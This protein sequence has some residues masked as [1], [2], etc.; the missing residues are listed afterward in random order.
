MVSVVITTCNRAEIL[1][2]ALV[3]VLSQTYTA[4]EIIV[5]DDG[6]TDETAAVVAQYGQR[7][8]YVRQ[9]NQGVE[10]ARKRGIQA[11]LGD[12]ITFLDDDDLMAPRKIERQAAILD[13]R[14][15]VGVVHCGY[16]YIDKDGNILGMSGRLPE[17]DMRRS[18]VWGCSPWSGGPLIRRQC[19]DCFGAEE[20]PDWYSD[21]GMWLRITLVGNQWACVQEPLGDYRIVQGSMIDN[22]IPNAERLV[23]HLL[24]EVFGNWKLP[25]E[26]LAEKDDIYAGWHFWISCRYYTVGSWEDAQRNLVKC[27]QL[28]PLLLDHPEKLI[29]LLHRDATSPRVR[30]HD[31]IRFVKDVFDHLPPEASALTHLRSLLLSRVCSEM[32]ILNYGSGRAKEARSQLG[33]ALRLT[34]SL[35]ER[36]ADFITQLS[37]YMQGAP[38]ILPHDYI[39]TML[40]DLPPEAES[41][42]RSRSR[43][44]AAAIIARAFNAY[45]T[46]S[47]SSVPKHV[48]SAIWKDPTWLKNR[49]VLAVFIK[50]LPAM[51]PR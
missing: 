36:P 37:S 16:R 49:R 13:S 44:L 1:P 14:S 12:Y 48:L 35:I 45:S 18:L 6:S 34:P 40:L 43:L 28:R 9:S 15:E 19:F 50:S 39:D 23:F 24:Q 31:P 33:E 47:R 25:R 20:H 5:V 2:A 32:A 46:G 4:I 30:V 51:L 10:M 11:S 7:V 8:R 22:R 41:L 29:E 38:D 3:S 26:I 27:L 42:K 21:W 17:G